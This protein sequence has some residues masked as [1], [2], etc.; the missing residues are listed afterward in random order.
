MNSDPTLPRRKTTQLPSHLL[1]LLHLLPARP[2]RPLRLGGE[3]ALAWP[4]P[5]SCR[6]R[7]S[8]PLLRQR[9]RTPTLGVTRVT[10]QSKAEPQQQN[11]EAR[12]RHLLATRYRGHQT[13]RLPVPTRLGAAVL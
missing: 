2:S 6:G 3:P 4:S 12:N 10:V 5:P 11:P 9:N 1:S 8:A 7:E 13:V